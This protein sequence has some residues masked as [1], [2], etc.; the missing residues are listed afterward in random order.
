MGRLTLMG[1][2]RISLSVRASAP[3]SRSL[4]P[5]CVQL[6]IS[7]NLPPVD[8]QCTA[9]DHTRCGPRLQ[10]TLHTGCRSLRR[11]ARVS[12]CHQVPRPAGDACLAMDPLGGFVTF[13]SRRCHP[14]WATH[15]RTP[16]REPKRRSLPDP[17]PHKRGNGTAR[18]FS[19]PPSRLAPEG[20]Y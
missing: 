6:F 11:G 14:L 5:G 4:P 12:R 3:S 7:W 19:P 10:S 13:G 1:M 16:C 18:R 17:Q 8:E 15:A 9:K 2:A 20:R